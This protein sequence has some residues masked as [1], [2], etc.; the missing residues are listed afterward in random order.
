ML[1]AHANVCSTIYVVLVCVHV[2]RCGDI[3]RQR[4]E[5]TCIDKAIM[6]METKQRGPHAMLLKN[7]I[8]HCSFNGREGYWTC[9]CIVIRG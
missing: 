7:C 9:L 6:E 4:G 3:E 5:R 1:I 8:I 2:H